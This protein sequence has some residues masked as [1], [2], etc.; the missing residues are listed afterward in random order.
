MTIQ[1]VIDYLDQIFHPEFQEHYDN[2]GFLLG[3]P[4]VVVSGVLVSID[5]TP[6]VIAEAQQRGCNLIVTHHPFIF[7]GIKRIT[8]ANETGRMIYQ[9]IEN[10]I[11]IYAAHT[12][13]DN[14]PNGVNGILAEKLGLEDCHILHAI[15]DV[16]TPDNAPIGAGAIGVLPHPVPITEW[17]E[18]LKETLHIPILRISEPCHINIQHIAICGGAGSFLIEDAI[19]AGADVLVTSDL[20]YHDFQKAEGRIVLV[21]A[22]HYESEQFAKEL[23][24]CAISKKFR[25]FA[26]CISD[27]T[28]SYIRYI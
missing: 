13:L 2:A 27:A 4:A 23:I 16:H 9:L 14:L 24:S 21:D 3:N 22:G 25:N 8:P 15:P 17:L 5:L 28:N 1:D 18:V 11:A 6:S 10:H 20:K 19:Q 7:G 26:T 12:N